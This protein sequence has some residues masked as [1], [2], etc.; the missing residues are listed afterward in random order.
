MEN[1]MSRYRNV[2]ILVAILFVQVLGLGGFRF[3]PPLRPP[4]NLLE[5][6][7]CGRSARS[8]PLEEGHRLVPETGSA[9][10]GATY[11]YLRGVRAGESRSEIR[12]RNS[13]GWS[14]CG[15]SDDAQQAPPAAG[16]ARFQGTVHREDCGRA[17]HRLQWQ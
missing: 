15:L 5:S 8:T 14:R 16:I 17:S 10:C 7:A 2:T 11:I 13:S 12:D 4:T 3:K 9:T 1:L 6:S